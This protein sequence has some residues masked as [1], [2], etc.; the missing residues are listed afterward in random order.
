MRIDGTLESSWHSKWSPMFVV[1]T[2]TRARKR[3]EGLCNLREARVPIAHRVANEA[4]DED[5]IAF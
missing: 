4:R 2:C 1:R 5:E 3:I